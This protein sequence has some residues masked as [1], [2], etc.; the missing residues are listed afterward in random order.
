MKD[1]LILF[2]HVNHVQK[3][4]YV[5]TLV[6]DLETSQVV[7]LVISVQQGRLTQQ[8]VLQEPSVL[9]HVV[10]PIHLVTNVMEDTTVQKNLQEE[11]LVLPTKPIQSIVNLVLLFLLHV[12]LDS[13]VTNLHFH[14]N[15]QFAQQGS[16]V[17]LKHL[18]QLHV[19]WVTTVLNKVHHQLH[20]QED[21][22]HVHLLNLQQDVPLLNLAKYVLQ[23]TLEMVQ[24]VISV[25]KVTTVNKEQLILIPLKSKLAMFSFVQLV[26]SV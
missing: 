12:V 8:L 23:V 14:Q 26:T 7:Q 2:Q 11:H 3:V 1:N 13:I 9:N 6:L 18:N 16:T 15:K 10:H 5:K 25:K 17:H 24:H 19:Q 20:V 21:T 22:V 4:T